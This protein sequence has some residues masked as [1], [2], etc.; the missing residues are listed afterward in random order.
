MPL[1]GGAARDGAAGDS[2]V[3]RSAREPRDPRDES[4]STSFSFG[5]RPRV[6]PPWRAGRSREERPAT[7]RCKTRRVVGKKGAVGAG[8]GEP[9]A[10]VF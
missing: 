10:N 2:A 7:A 4:R 9:V 6:T 5:D 3:T 8:G 1:P